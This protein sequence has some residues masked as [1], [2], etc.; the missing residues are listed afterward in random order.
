ME[1]KFIK[2]ENIDKLKWDSCVHYAGNG[3]VYGYTWFLDNACEQWDGLVEGDY[4]SVFPLV[5]NTKLL[6]NKQLY[7]PIL[8]QQLG[9][10][11]VHMRSPARLRN[12]I[13][14]IPSDIKFIN[15]DLNEENNVKLDDSFQLTPRSNFLLNLNRPFEEIQKG[16]SKSLNKS[17]KKA[18]KFDFISSGNY[19]PETIVD[20]FVQ[21]Q[22][23]IG[24]E[25]DNHT[26]HALHR[27]MYNAMHRG[28]GSILANT[29]MDGNI[30]AATFL[31]YSHKRIIYF[32]AASTKE[33][34]RRCAMHYLLDNFFYANAGRPLTFDFEGSS[35]PGIATFFKAFGAAESKYYNLYKNNL[36]FWVKWVKKDKK[37]LFV[38]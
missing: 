11:S 31:I 8:C 26:R 13:N 29:D 21:T 4:E 10:Y 19:K 15:I 7:Q 30:L 2:R 37:N 35:L 33:G 38:F 27:I 23:E 6:G 22:K 34:K 3:N 18:S 5:W 32:L 17:L 20:L 12:F 25:V 14:A 16:Y 24:N 9:I 1:I 36:P 28:R